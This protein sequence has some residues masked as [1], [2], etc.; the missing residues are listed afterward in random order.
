MQSILHVEFCTCLWKSHNVSIYVEEFKYENLFLIAC[1]CDVNTMLESCCQEFMNKNT[2]AYPSLMLFFLILQFLSQWFHLLIP[3]K[4]SHHCELL[5]DRY[6]VGVIAEHNIVSLRCQTPCLISK[7][8]F[9]TQALLPRATYKQFL[10][11]FGKCSH[12]SVFVL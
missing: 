5:W 9:T 7:T 6:K 3:H 1:E 2:K 12:T 10:R 11:G 8:M 4:Q